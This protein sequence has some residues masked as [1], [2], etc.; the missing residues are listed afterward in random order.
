MWPLAA[1]WVA[2]PE[3]AKAVSVPRRLN[4]FANFIIFQERSS[5]EEHYTHAKNFSTTAYII[6]RIWEMDKRCSV[7]NQQYY[8]RYKQVYRLKYL[9]LLLVVSTERSK[10]K[11]NLYAHISISAFK[12]MFCSLIKGNRLK[13]YKIVMIIVPIELNH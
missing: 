7:L 13:P 1:H 4:C 5:L 11:L 9:K 2:A 8:S 12:V 10:E 3:T 6:Y